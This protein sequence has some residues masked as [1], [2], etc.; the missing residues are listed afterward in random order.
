MLFFAGCSEYGAECFLC[1]HW[2]PTDVGFASEL[3]AKLT[4]LALFL[5]TLTDHAPQA[6]GKHLTV[7]WRATLHSPPPCEHH[8]IVT[9][10]TSLFPSCR[11]HS[12]SASSWCLAT[13]CCS[14]PSTPPHSS[15]S[16]WV[17]P[18]S[19]KYCVCSHLMLWDLSG[20]PRQVQFDQWIQLL[21]NNRCI[22]QS[23]WNRKGEMD[24]K[25]DD[26]LYVCVLSC[27]VDFEVCFGHFSV[28]YHCIEASIC[29]S[30]QTWNC[31]LGM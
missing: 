20:Q 17:G 30:L 4:C 11:S 23:K 18:W 25:L 31:Y 26:I 10:D 21:W 28:G 24:W 14:R 22:C 6:A 3:T 16:G 27:C 13:P 9:N 7:A 29:S 8:R 19:P 15:P 1:D 12:A 5:I 2:K